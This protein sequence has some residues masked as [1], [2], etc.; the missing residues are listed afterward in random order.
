MKTA[1]DVIHGQQITIQM[2]NK[3]T[4]DLEHRVK[5]LEEQLN[6]AKETVRQ[7][8]I[9]WG[10]SA[11]TELDLSN[12][13]LQK[14]YWTDEA[15]KKVYDW[16]LDAAMRIAKATN[17]AIHQ[18]EIIKEARRLHPELKNYG[19]DTLTARIRDMCNKYGVLTR[20]KEGYYWPSK[21]ALD[22]LKKE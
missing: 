16:L 15:Y 5:H 18:S 14:E 19:E 10:L 8:T 12:I 11:P 9:Q 7:V 3:L 22:N 4:G 2:L 13:H 6:L 20:I 1:D 17:T 21:L